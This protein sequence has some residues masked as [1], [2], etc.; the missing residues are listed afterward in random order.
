MMFHH[1]SHVR[2]VNTNENQVI[3]RQIR[4]TLPAF[5]HDPINSREQD[6]S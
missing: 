4:V 5:S 6:A 1:C 3:R 2:V